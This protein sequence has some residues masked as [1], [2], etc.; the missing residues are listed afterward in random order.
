V[1]SDPELDVVV[2]GAGFSG[3]YLL[4]RLRGMGLRVRVLERATGVGGTWHWNRYPGAR[5]DIESV[6]YQ[7]SF[8]P[9]L[10][11]EWRWKERYAAQPEIL[12]YLEHV[13]DRYDL[14]RDIT[15]G[16]TVESATYDD[17]TSTWTLT[18]D[19]GERVTA[20]WCVM[21]TG[22]LST[23]KPP[24]IPGLDTFEG[25]WLHTG[26]WPA[27]PVEL[28]GKR[29]AVVGTGSS[30]VQTITALAP[31]VDRLFVLQ[32]T[33]NYS[34]PA[35]NRPLEQD[36]WERIVEDFAQRRYLCETG[37]AGTPLPL[38][39]TPAV[40]ATPEERRARYEAGWAM[41]GI[42]SL[43]FAFNDMFRD[44]RSNAYAAEFAR[45]KIRSIVKDPVVAEKLC[46]THHIGT[47]RTCTDTGYFETFNR[48]NVELVDLNDEPIVEI[49][50]SGIRTS[51]RTIDVDVIVFAIGFDAITGAMTE[52]DVRG[53]GGL[54]LS[55]AW[56]DGP[57]TYL[58]LQ[59]AGFPNL[60]MVT[61]PASPSV[62]SNMV[63]SIEQHVDWIA[64]CI[65]HLRETGADTI[66]AT[67][68]AQDDW[69]A[70]VTDLASSTLYPKSRSWYV[71]A[72]I[73]GK[74]QGFTVYIAGC[75]PYRE[76]CE[77]VVADGYRGFRITTTSRQEAPA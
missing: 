70:H 8:D 31:Q 46:P 12:A 30:G 20:R 26:E 77:R 11:K 62:L 29:V 6:D 63:V 57:R 10:V 15:F 27:E 38:P 69:M 53:R 50:P 3:L 9:E 75:G 48:D 61:G 2:V 37:D 36:E 59:V 42:S 55:Q 40:E 54:P 56:E 21:A 76:E 28:E 58:G 64:D 1:P 18:T 44:E 51:E 74:P 17:G 71:G 72:N 45:E 16:V 19:A 34:M 13:A 67:E 4:H 33:P 73:E 22:N 60:F 5:C 68:Q 24:D 52:I 35:H 65:D 7:Y 14:R 47:K 32:R 43:S 66:E 23:V 39:T 41:G 25:T 49:V